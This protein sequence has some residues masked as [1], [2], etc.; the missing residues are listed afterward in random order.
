MTM[1]GL[2]TAIR[3]CPSNS[4]ENY[5]ITHLISPSRFHEVSATGDIL[6]QQ[7]HEGD[8]VKKKVS[9]A[10]KP[11]KEK[12]RKTSSLPR[13]ALSSK[14]SSISSN[15]YATKS[16]SSI[17]SSALA[18]DSKRTLNK[19]SDISKTRSSKENKAASTETRRRT[20]REESSDKKRERKSHNSARESDGLVDI[21]FAE[22]DANG[23]QEEKSSDRSS[24]SIE[25]SSS[26]ENR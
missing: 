1:R 21:L 5:M 2:P 3:T 4:T 12:L 15:M 7:L 6:Q 20:H 16:K 26:R 22:G 8:D 10:S 17:K 11:S 13:K 24:N 14:S 9:A 18:K 19:G 23:S 25:Y